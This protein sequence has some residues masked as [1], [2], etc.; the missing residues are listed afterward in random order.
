MATVLLSK[1]QRTLLKTTSG[2][3]DEVTVEVMRGSLTTLLMVP[4][5]II[6]LNSCAQPHLTTPRSAASVNRPLAPV[7]K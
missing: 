2:I 6:R 3:P 5:L 4:S 7:E 1:E